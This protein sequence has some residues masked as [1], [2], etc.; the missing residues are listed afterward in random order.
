MSINFLPGNFLGETL[1]EG[2]KTWTWDGQ[3]WNLSG[4]FVNGN[5][6]LTTGDAMT[7]TLEIANEGNATNLDFD[8]DK[9]NLTFTTTKTDGSD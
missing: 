3:K 6:V 7:G 1:T 9:A 2:G 4:S 5:F 8:P